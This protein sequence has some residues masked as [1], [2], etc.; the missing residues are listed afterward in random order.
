[1]K[2]KKKEKEEDKEE[3]VRP[4]VNRKTDRFFIFGWEKLNSIFF[5]FS[6]RY[7][8][9]ARVSIGTNGWRVADMRRV[10]GREEDG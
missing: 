8:L 3:I 1:M 9:C 6:L 2:G 5:F 4:Y 10:D 7:T